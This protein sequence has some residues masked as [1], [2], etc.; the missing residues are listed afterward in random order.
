MT[1]LYILMTVTDRHRPVTVALVYLQR[2]TE[3]RHATVT[4]MTLLVTVT[5]T[6][7]GP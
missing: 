3:L 1:E 4:K 2:L 5:A 7:T 6:V